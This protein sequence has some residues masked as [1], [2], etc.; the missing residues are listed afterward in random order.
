M[1]KKQENDS[2]SY[3]LS[4]ITDLIKELKKEI[5]NQKDEYLTPAEAAI[6]LKCT[7]RTVFNYSKRGWLDPKKVGKRVFYT[8][9]SI[10]DIL[11]GRFNNQSLTPNNQ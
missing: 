2:G 3:S 10:M 7:K 4:C 8:R 5:S 11:E 9:K 6:I 1:S